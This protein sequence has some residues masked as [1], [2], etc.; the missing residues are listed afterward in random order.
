MA[1][2]AAQACYL[3]LLNGIVVTV[4]VGSIPLG[5][6]TGCGGGGG[7]GGGNDT[8]GSSGDGQSRTLSVSVS[9]PG[10]G[11]IT[12][13][14]AGISC[15]T[16][17]TAQFPAGEAIVLTASPET[18][19]VFAGWDG[20]CA[21]TEKS[22]QVAMSQSHSVSAWFSPETLTRLDIK[23]FGQGDVRVTVTEA[24]GASELTSEWCGP[25]RG[26]GDCLYS[27]K[28]GTSV[29]LVPEAS[30]GWE[31]SHWLGC[32]EV[33]REECVITIHDT[34]LTVLPTF[35]DSQPL[36]LHDDVVILSAIMVESLTGVTADTLTFASDA[37][38]IADLIPGAV[39]VSTVGEGFARRVLGVTTE[40]DEVRV[41]TTLASMEDVIREA[42]LVS[43]QMLGQAQLLEADLAPGVRIVEPQ[44]FEQWGSPLRLE[45]NTEES[46]IWPEHY[47]TVKGY[48]D[49]T[50]RHDFAVDIRWH[51]GVQEFRFGLD[52]EVG[53]DLEVMLD[54]MPEALKSRIE[55]GR[56][57]FAVIVVGPVAFT[58]DVTP[59][60]S[61]EGKIEAEF[62]PGLKGTAGLVGGV[63]YERGYGWDRFSNLRRPAFELRVDDLLNPEGLVALEVQGGVKAGLKVYGVAGPFLD[64]GM[65]IEPQLALRRPEACYQGLLDGG[66]RM[67]AGGSARFLAWP[68]GSFAFQLFDWKM[69]GYNFWDACGSVSPLPPQSL[70]LP[71]SI[72][73]WSSD[74]LF[75]RFPSALGAAWY[76]VTR[77][78][79]IITS[80]ER[81][82]LLVTGLSPDTEYC[83]EV[84]PYDADGRS[85]ESP[86]PPGCGRTRPLEDVTVPSEPQDLQI[87]RVTATSLEISWSASFDENKV[88]GYMIALGANIVAAIDT[89][90][91][92]EARYSAML[93]S[94]SPDT[95]YCLRV[96]AFDAAGNAS[97]FSVEACGTTERMGAGELNDTGIT[98]CGTTS[99]GRLECPVSTHPN[100]D[101]DNGRD[102]LA[103][104]GRLEKIGVGDAGFDFTKL[105]SS[106]EPLPSTAPAWT[107]VRDNH[108]GLIWEVKS[109][110]GGLHDWRHTY[111][112][113]NP[114]PATNGGRAGTPD[115]GNC[116]GSACDTHAFAVAVNE[117][118]FCGAS[119]WR[120]PN[121]KELMSI[122][123]NGRL[124]PAIDTSLFPNTRISLDPNTTASGY[125]S[126]T[127]YHSPGNTS[128]ARYVNFYNGDISMSSK[129]LRQ[130]PVRLVRSGGR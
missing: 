4:L 84:L 69:I 93:S 81:N 77:W 97:P 76:E 80:T 9:G 11:T 14:P 47:P 17:C 123:H 60:V 115:G 62:K 73:A 111:S 29:R 59:F 22:C 120:L 36:V 129:L 100:Q 65:Y 109:V 108:T 34:H 43:S 117:R 45:L 37:P 51:T 41:Q 124:N 104:A 39:I 8:G 130:Y 87:D 110:D 126:S 99:Q 116:A 52:A 122:V 72:E 113:Y 83:F 89:R 61:T 40:G 31:F 107:C 33:D 56:F 13:V 58:V 16:T 5:V 66:L 128:N 75:I 24:E 19:S 70:L 20:A 88:V 63:Q 54:L 10:A 102:A 57:T 101:G 49:L 125:W 114:D 28:P 7:T 90:E 46:E 30:P 3:R 26:P 53:G 12:S 48:L 23:R 91:L 38:Q 32:E 86:S 74:T 94:L 103:R 42:V 96:A 95:Q 119:N 105:D 15:G 55:F 106:G 98:W 6:L 1:T 18:G 118:N 35:V 44:R 112:W 85:A 50:L 127:P 25:R 27:L 92:S 21:G 2:N 82:N 79:S 71:P 67:S 64:L 78:P 121:V 68:L